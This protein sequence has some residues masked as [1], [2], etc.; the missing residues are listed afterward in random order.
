MVGYTQKGF[1]PPN[2]LTQ[3]EKDDHLGIHHPSF[4]TPTKSE[5]LKKLQGA[6]DGP[7]SFN[8]SAFAC[9]KANLVQNQYKKISAYFSNKV[10]EDPSSSMTHGHYTLRL[11]WMRLCPTPTVL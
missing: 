5:L 4:Q 3:E 8:P 1:E 9:L 2:L 7:I 6:E 10:Q 11:A